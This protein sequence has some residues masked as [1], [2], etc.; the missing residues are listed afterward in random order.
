MKCLLNKLIND[1]AYI[2]D[3][4]GYRDGVREK[5]VEAVA[6][7]KKKYNSTII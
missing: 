3:T 2:H 1:F 4:V 6:P 7:A 5:S